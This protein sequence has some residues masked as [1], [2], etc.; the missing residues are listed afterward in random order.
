MSYRIDFSSVAKAEADAAF[1]SFAQFT[2]PE[3]AQSWY[4]GLI[5]AISSLKVMPRRCAL[6]RE[7][8][9]FNREIRQLIYGQGRHTYRI[10]FTILEDQKEPTVRILNIRNA[11]Q[12]T[13]G[14]P[15]EEDEL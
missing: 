3:R 4:Q 7:N 9:F 14:E 2:T 10:T 15:E 12:K 1:M 13:I 8:A 6:A 11:A 5:T